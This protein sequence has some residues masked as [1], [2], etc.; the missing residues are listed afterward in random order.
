M[1]RKALDRRLQ[2]LGIYSA[3]YYKKE[4]KPLAEVLK[5]DEQLNCVFTGVHENN[6]KLVALTDRRIIIIYAAALASGEIKSIPREFIKNAHYEGK[7]FFPK[8]TIITEERDY[9]FTGVQSGQ[10]PLFDWARDKL[11]D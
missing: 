4:L 5:D 3:Y 10:K 1:D 9:I 2:E 7:F 11:L 6:R 8:A